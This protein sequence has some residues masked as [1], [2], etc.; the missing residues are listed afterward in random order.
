MLDTTT[1]FAVTTIVSFLVAGLVLAVWRRDSRYGG[2]RPVKLGL[3][4][5][6]GGFLVQIGRAHV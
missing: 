6:A 4:L 1:L 3:S 2:M 5:L